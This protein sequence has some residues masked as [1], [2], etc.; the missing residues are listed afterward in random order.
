LKRLCLLA[1]MLLPVLGSMTDTF[2][3]LPAPPSLGP[4][5]QTI[6]ER[7]VDAAREHNV[8]AAYVL[9][10]MAAESSYDAAAVSPAGA[11]GLMQLMPATAEEMGYDA[12]DWQENIEAGT[13][14]LGYLLQR[15]RHRRNGV[16][17]A[18]AAYNAGPANV[19][20]Y[21]GIPPFRETR[22]YVKRVLANYAEIKR[23][24]LEE[25]AAD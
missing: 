12:S 22:T 14:Y 1:A 11:I 16:Q 21:N 15:Y 8:D 6:V 25:V 9:S 5:R 19:D 20:R 3:T 24:P 17:L 18:I 13:H 10:V 23:Q 4:D 7:A 2:L